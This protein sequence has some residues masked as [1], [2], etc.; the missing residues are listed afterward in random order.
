MDGHTWGYQ[1]RETEWAPKR[2]DKFMYTGCV[3]TVTLSET[4]GLGKKVGRL[5]IGLQVGSPGRQRL[6]CAESTRGVWVS[7][8]FGIAIGIKVVPAWH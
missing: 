5:G 2:F 4:P 7:D 6:I 1:P 3:E 8:H